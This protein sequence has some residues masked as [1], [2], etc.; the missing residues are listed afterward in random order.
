MI[1]AFKGTTQITR[2][3][4]KKGTRVTKVRNFANGLLAFDYVIKP[5]G[6]IFDEP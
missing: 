3:S 4:C 2:S 5:S 6:W 1:L